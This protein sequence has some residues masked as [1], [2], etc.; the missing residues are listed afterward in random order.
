MEAKAAV[1]R[2]VAEAGTLELD[3]LGVNSGL[4]AY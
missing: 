2:A 1:P 3:S 4:T